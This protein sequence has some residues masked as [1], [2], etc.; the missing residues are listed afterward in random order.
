MTKPPKTDE[1]MDAT[2][3]FLWLILALMN[4]LFWYAFWLYIR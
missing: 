1:F 3:K 4:A 2:M